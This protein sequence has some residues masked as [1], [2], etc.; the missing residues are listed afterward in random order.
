[1]S[2]QLTLI[3]L[4]RN[5]RQ[6]LERNLPCIFNQTLDDMK[7]LLSDHSSTDGSYE[8]LC[9]Q[10][11]KYEG[12]KAVEVVR[13]PLTESVGIMGMNA[14]L[15]WAMERVDTPYTMLAS[16][17]DVCYP[18]YAERTLDA[19]ETHQPDYVM[20]RS[21]FVRDGVA[22]HETP[23]IGHDSFVPLA[24][25][26]SY[27]LSLQNGCAWTRDLWNHVAPLRG[28][29]APDLILPGMAAIWGGLYMIDEVLHDSTHIADLE[30]VSCERAMDAVQGDEKIRLS[31]ANAY[32]YS[33]S[34]FALM[35]RMRELQIEL[36]ANT[37]QVLNA[38]LM[39]AADGWVKIRDFLT[40][41]RIAPVGLRV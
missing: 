9:E 31:E 32:Q 8:L 19:F 30:G 1:M 17:D 41:K 16:A 21:R 28:I 4:A 39:T 35:E 7:L 14:H 23:S 10:A 15:M 6:M 24:T 37:I 38:K 12:G 36:S 27:N 11:A 40:V 3:L 18:H 34:H 2:T 20:S 5:K 22:E 26:L 25:M 29:E 13:C 33:S